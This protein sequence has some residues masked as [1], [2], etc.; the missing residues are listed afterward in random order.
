MSKTLTEV[1]Q[2][3]VRLPASERLQLARI[4]LDLS[5]PYIEPDAEVQS[6]W[7]KEIERRL[8]ELRS[9]K[10]KAIPLEEVKK[11]IEKRFRS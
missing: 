9:G 4:L 7:D 2:E 8:H 11:K 6:A 3:A 1:T 10:V 5:E